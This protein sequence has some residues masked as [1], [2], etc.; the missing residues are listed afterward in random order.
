MPSQ[1]R[2]SHATADLQKAKMRYTGDEDGVT[3]SL[4]NICALLSLLMIVGMPFFLA[5][6]LRE[7]LG[8][9]W[10]VGCL[11]FFSIEAMVFLCLLLVAFYERFHGASRGESMYMN[12]ETARP[13]MASAKVEPEFFTPQARCTNTSSRR[14]TRS[15]SAT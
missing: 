15:R 2:R 12:G 8:L 10:G 3:S 11:I 7:H 13:T 14:H 4:R 5:E 6:L 9:A 1:I